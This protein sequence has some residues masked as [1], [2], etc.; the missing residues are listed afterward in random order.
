MNIII[1]QTVVL[2]KIGPHCYNI[3]LLMDNNCSEHGS[4]YLLQN[5]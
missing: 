1:D 2:A 4:W 5:C 3:L